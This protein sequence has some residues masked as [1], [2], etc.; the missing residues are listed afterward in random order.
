MLHAV[1][2][3]AVLWLFWVLQTVERLLRESLS[4]HVSVDLFLDNL[5][6]CQSVP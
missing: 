1:L 3:R 6:S 2:C 5:T 4:L